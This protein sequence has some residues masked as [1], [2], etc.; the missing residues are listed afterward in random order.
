MPAAAP[1]F[2]LTLGIAFLLYASLFLLK[3]R[4]IEEKSQKN[5]FLGLFGFCL[6]WGLLQIMYYIS[7]TYP[8]DSLMALTYYKVAYI[9][10]IC[11]FLSLLLVIEKYAVPRTKFFFSIIT[12][13]GLILVIILPMPPGTQISGARLASY[14]FLPAGA[15]SIFF[16][17]LYLI[18]KLS[19]PLRRETTLI[20][21]GFVLLFIG[22]VLTTSLFANFQFLD[23]DAWNIMCYSFMLVGGLIVTSI[24]YRRNI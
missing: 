2:Q 17:Y 20:L 22:Y 8:E 9:V 6:G 18:F 24:Y 19:G 5:F 12:A 10:G 3:I 21:L 7:G 11:G 13:F 1:I 23:E 14:I 15:I 4:R 16:L